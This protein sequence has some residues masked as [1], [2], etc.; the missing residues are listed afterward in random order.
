MTTI[1]GSRYKCTVCTDYDL[2]EKCYDKK[3]H[4]S[5]HGFNKHDKEMYI[6]NMPQ[7]FSGERTAEDIDEK[8]DS[9]EEVEKKVKQLAEV[10][11]KGK[12][13]VVYTGAGVSTS[14]KI[15]DYR[16]PSG[17]WT[18]RDKGMVP[19]MPITI[20]QALPTPTHMALYA[21][22]KKGIVKFV[23]STNVD[24]LHRR[25]GFPANA[26]AEL[27][28]NCY[29]E[30]CSN[31]ECGKE[32]LR[33]HDVTGDG[34]MSDHRTGHKCDSCGSDLKD[35]I[36]NFGENLPDIELK[37]T[38]A[39]ANKSDVA[40]VLG[41]SMRVA[42]ANKFP[43]H[44]QMNGGKMVI[45]NLQVTPYDNKANIII[46]DKTDK[47]MQMLCKE[48]GVDIPDYKMEQDEIKNIDDN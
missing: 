16:G 8:Y 14:A 1:I 2:C 25:S 26:M 21:L 42:P 5:S 20:E 9:A 32:F 34:V 39:E 30:L 29:K 45:V 18:L 38:Y 6:P 23:V 48:L 15:P 36:I 28:G 12:H 19:F 11:K 13:I 40:L 46:R 4:D 31:K 35:T 27:H 41:T 44:A 43:S 47:V 33:N 37:K 22:W 24:G 7:T 17:V 3:E 10:V